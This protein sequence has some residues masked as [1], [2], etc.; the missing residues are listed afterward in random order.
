MNSDGNSVRV[1]MSVTAAR[2]Q[3]AAEAALLADTLSLPFSGIVTSKTAK[4]ME[5]WQLQVNDNDRIIIRPDG[6]RVSIDFAN[7]KAALRQQQAAKDQSLIRALGLHKLKLTERQALHVID[8]TGGF[9]QDAWIIASQGCSVTVLEASALM[10]TLLAHAIEQ[11]ARIDELTAIANNINVIHARSQDYMQ[12]IDSPAPD[13]IYLD[14]MF[15]SRK[16]QAKVKKSMQFL[17]E[18]L[19]T[20]DDSGL[21]PAALQTA[22]DRVV[23][24]RPKSASPLNSDNWQG[25]TTQLTTD[26]MRFDIYHLARVTQSRKF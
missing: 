15:P 3:D 22:T 26:A 13:M 23:V 20:V 16:K 6:A 2:P 10:A 19:P 4:S 17:H 1:E 18:L 24:K 5:T 9:G 7:G 21:L 14:P 8:G 25:Q 12:T 11:A